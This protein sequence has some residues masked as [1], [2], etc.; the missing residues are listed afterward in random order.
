MTDLPASTSDSPHELLSSTRDLT[1]RVRDAQRGAWFPLL[2]VAAVTFGAA[3]VD[4]VDHGHAVLNCRVITA[5]GQSARLCTYYYPGSFVYWPIALMLAYAAT[6]AFY[7]RRSRSRGVGT[8]IR[9]YVVAGVALAVLLTAASLWASYHPPGANDFDLFGIH[10][11][12]A[13]SLRT[14][15]YRLTGPA[16]GIGLA[17]LVLARLERSLAL[18]VFTLGYL[19]VVLVPIDFGWVITR[20]SPWFFLPHLVVPGTVLLLGALGFGAAQ[21]STS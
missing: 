3:I 10:L 6:A 9:P 13:S 11:S 15:P 16:A 8:R 19:L 4:R 17:L 7:L 1:R 2:L 14:L 20:P 5:P 18:L 12:T 21:R